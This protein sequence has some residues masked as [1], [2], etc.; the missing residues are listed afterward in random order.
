MKYFS[1][2]ALLVL[3]FIHTVH[4]QTWNGSAS[5]VWSNPLNWTPNTV[6]GTGSA[7]SIPGSLGT[8]PLLSANVTIASLT[9]AAGA[10]LNTNGKTITVNGA[11][12][13]NQATMSGAGI[14]N[15]NAASY[16]NLQ[17]NT[18]TVSLNILSFYGSF[19]SY[20]NLITGTSTFSDSIAQGGLL[21]FGGNTYNGNLTFTHKSPNVA[22]LQFGGLANETVNGNVVYINQGTGG[23]FYQGYG[24]TLQVNGNMTVNN[25]NGAICYLFYTPGTVTGNL[26]VTSPNGGSILMNNIYSTN[27]TIGG[28]LNL[29]GTSINL[30]MYRIKNNTSGGSINL[31]NPLDINMQADTLSVSTLTMTNVQSA[32][33]MY[34]NAVTATSTTISDSSNLG[35]V[36]YI[37]GNT[38]I[39]SYSYT[40]KSPAAMYTSYGGNGVEV[41]YGP[42]TYTSSQNGNSMYL[43]YG[44]PVNCSNSFTLNNNNGANVSLFMNSGAVIGNC[45]LN[46]PAGGSLTMNNTSYPTVN[47]TGTLNITSNDA[48]V[49]IYKVKNNLTG[50]TLNIINPPG[51]AFN[52]DSIKATV[53]ILNYRNAFELYNNQITGTVVLSDS[54]VQAGP[55]YIG[56]NTI[57]GNFTHTHKANYGMYECYGGNNNNTYNGNVNYNLEPTGSSLILGYNGTFTTTG[58]LTVQNNSAGTSDFFNIPGSIGGNFTYNAPN[59]GSLEC[60]ATSSTTVVNGTINMNM[61]NNFGLGFYRMKNNTAGGTIQVTNASYINFNSDSLKADIQIP[62]YN[63]FFAFHDNSVL[64]NVTLS[65]SSVQVNTNYMGGNTIT[66]NFSM[67]HKSG[68]PFYEAY[69]GSSFDTYNG[70]VVFNLSQSG[71]SMQCGYGGVLTVNGNLTINNNSG[72]YASFFSVGG[73]VSGNLL[74]T[75]PIGGSM[76]FNSTSNPAV[77]I[78][79]TVNMTATNLSLEFLTMKNNTAGGTIALTGASSLHFEQDTLMV[80]T[81]IINYN[82]AMNMMNNKFTGNTTI[83]SAPSQVNG[84]NYIGGNHFNGDYTVNHQGQSVL[85]SGYGSSFSNRI[86]GN[87]SYTNTGSFALDLGYSYPEIIEKNLSINN[88]GNM[89]IRQVSLAG[90]TDGHIIQSGSGPIEIQYLTLSKVNPGKAI[91]DNKIT[92]TNTMYFITGY[93]MS[94]S[95]AWLAFANGTTFTGAA[96]NSHVIGSVLKAGSQLFTF[97]LGNGIGYHPLGITAPSSA[98]DSLLASIVLKNPTADGFNTASKVAA[99]VQIAPYH[100]WQLSQLSGSFNPTVSLGWSNPCMNAGITSVPAMAVSRWNG[101]QWAN[102]GNSA[103]TGTNASGTVTQTGTTTPGTFALATTTAANA[104]QITSVSSSATTVCSGSPVTLTAAGA[105][106]YSWQPGG[107]SGISVVVNPTATTTYTVT[108]TS[109][110]GCITTAT[111]TINV[112]PLPNTNTTVTLSAICV[113]QQSTTLTGTGADTYTWQPGGATT[114]AITV[115]P[116][117]TTTYTVTG[118]IT[119]TGCTKTATRIITVNSLP[120]VGTTVTN[121]TI[122]AGQ[123]TSIT[124]TGATTYT[125]MPGSLSGTTI[126]VSPAT[127][128]TYTVTGTNA[129]GCTATSTRTITVNSLP[130]VGTTVTNAT[131]CAGQSTSITGTGANTYAWMPGSLSGT[132]ITVT[133][134]STTTYTVTGTNTTTGCTNTATRI[135]TVNS[136]PTVGTTVTNA[137]ICIGQ[138]TSITGT[139]ANTY[140]WMPGSLSGTTIT[141]TPA[142]TTTYTVTGTNTTTGCTNTTTRTITVNSLPTVGTTVSNATICAGSSTSITGTG[143]STYTWM[144]GSLSGTTI[145]VSPASTTT[146][147]VTGT[148]AAGCTGTA[149]R[150]ITVNN[151][152]SILN[153]KAYIEGYYAGA[154]VMAPVLFNSG[155]TANITLAD[156]VQVQLRNTAS[157]FGIAASI[158]VVLATNGTATCIFPPLNGNYYVAVK[159]RNMVETWSANPVSI[160]TSVAANYDFTT[161]LTKAYGNN[162]VQMSASPLRFAFF[163]GDIIQDENV[164]LLDLSLLDTDINN[165]LFGYQVSDLNGDGNVDLLDMPAIETNANNF[166]SSAH[167]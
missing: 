81:S 95:T 122:C 2:L 135:I 112:N 68:F 28:T 118:T 89:I 92:V 87:A 43:G 57:N 11:L 17:N 20:N 119:A 129:N 66:G 75:A 78:G 85:Y 147:T 48:V 19:S 138:S 114:A 161:A 76:V 136:L 99:L 124:G 41:F 34:N 116:A 125:W 27:S 32:V 59:G 139:G 137:S 154:G 24:G 58:N 133:P 102:L 84:F 60:N 93:L 16:V 155:L 105:N 123:S 54:S 38:Y 22:Y 25:T 26:T 12:D 153:L 146:Y 29:S 14:L 18:L 163:S 7:V 132:T 110:T 98:T 143:A 152:N 8:Y 67:T 108:G 63:G 127:T 62:N 4:A 91:L 131:L 5:N 158:K 130:S 55:N 23:N 1:L 61:A 82:N 111:K 100:Y 70:N 141:V 47:I 167:P 46:A 148:S 40:H 150:T 121:A 9:M 65:D 52:S 96:D 144:P 162:M 72:G 103:T 30:G 80:T 115:S 53:N 94:T 165:F 88:N 101:S 15:C 6:P 107:L 33:T 140:A 166:V 145:N 109:A 156:T 120:A 3:L 79:G 157:P 142:S 113:G 45:T 39:G 21:Y 97:P 77:T 13:I 134:A 86:S 44:G 37:G 71:N 51:I 128:T 49:G 50:G 104:W 164:D 10:V 159:G 69:G 42:V 106:T 56:G 83:Q 90:N 31:V 151:C 64:G 160:S 35:G 149:T 74:V 73:Q 126:N 36:I 117:A